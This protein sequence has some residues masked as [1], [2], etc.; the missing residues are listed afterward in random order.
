MSDLI[1]QGIRAVQVDWLIG[2]LGT[3]MF[4]NGSAKMEFQNN[5]LESKKGLTLINLI[6]LQVVFWRISVGVVYSW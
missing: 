5:I 4:D 6:C 3:V 2:N 1:S